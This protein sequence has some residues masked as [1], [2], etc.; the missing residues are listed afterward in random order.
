MTVTSD[1]L[2]AKRPLDSP[3]RTAE[4]Q[5]EAAFER[6]FLE[7]YSR[8]YG[9]LFRLVGDR[10]EAEDLA[11]ETFWRL[12]RQ[13]P[14]N[15]Q[16][17]GGWLYR[18]ATNLGLNSIRAGRRRQQ[19]EQDAGRWESQQKPGADPEEVAA[20]REARRQVREILRR[21]PPRQTQLLVL[22]HSG[23]SYREIAEAVGVAPGSVGTLLARAEKEFARLYQQVWGLQE[24]DRPN[25]P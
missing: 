10:A 21:L 11:L 1:K 15:S 17:I 20:A 23:L 16:N 6:V 25:A 7:H 4:A 5:A 13:P 3:A 18:V 19:H 14:R 24:G 22:R 9:V 12:H 8:V 2:R